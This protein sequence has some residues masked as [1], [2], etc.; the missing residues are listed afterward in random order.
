MR[1]N[2]KFGFTSETTLFEIIEKNVQRHDFREGGGEAGCIGLIGMQ[3]PCL[4]Y[5]R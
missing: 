3:G 4:Y 5:H 2:I 1:R